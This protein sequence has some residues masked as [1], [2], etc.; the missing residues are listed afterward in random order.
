MSTLRFSCLVSRSGRYNAAVRDAGWQRPVGMVFDNSGANV[1]R[2]PCTRGGPKVAGTWVVHSPVRFAALHMATKTWPCH[3][4]RATPARPGWHPSRARRGSPDPVVGLTEGLP[5]SFGDLRPTRGDLRSDPRRGQETR[6]EPAE[7]FGRAHDG[8]RRPAPS[9]RETYGRAHDGVRRP[10][11]SPRETFGQDD[12]GVR[13]PAP[14][15]REL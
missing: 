7:T 2:N 4:D 9:P 13:R 12:D 5:S 1:N 15:P 3:P 10:A 11:P 8:V 6:A 14:S